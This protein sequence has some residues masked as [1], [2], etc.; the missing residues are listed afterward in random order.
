MQVFS[1]FP[2]IYTAVI[3]YSRCSKFESLLSAHIVRHQK[4]KSVDIYR[5]TLS[6]NIYVKY[7]SLQTFAIDIYHLNMF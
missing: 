2:F 4:L 6:N 1:H 5:Q 7:R 3:S